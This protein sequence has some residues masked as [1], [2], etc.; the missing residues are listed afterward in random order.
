MCRHPQK[1]ERL[2]G[3]LQPLDTGG[4][5]L[6]YGAKLF[7]EAVRAPSELQ[8][9]HIERRTSGTLPHQGHS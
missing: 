4:A 2:S 1:M 6:E 5:L 9:R 7:S 3:N 8:Q